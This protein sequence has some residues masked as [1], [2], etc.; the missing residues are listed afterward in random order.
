MAAL[1]LAAA[2]LILALA[3]VGSA[4]ADGNVTT[5]YLVQM[6]HLD[7]VRAVVARLQG[8]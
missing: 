2:V 1:F 3:P 5:V 8:L 4:S 6:N 7:V